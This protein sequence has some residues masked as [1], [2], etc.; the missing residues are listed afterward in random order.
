MSERVKV[1]NMTTA[2]IMVPGGVVE[3]GKSARRP[4]SAE[5]DEL[6]GVAAFRVVDDGDGDDPMEDL[7]GEQLNEALRARG[8]PAAGTVDEKRE[9][10]RQAPPEDDQPAGAGEKGGS[11]A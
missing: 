1:E 11:G 9:R 2:P 3:H 10:L 4:R 7:R 6:I 8:L 5:L